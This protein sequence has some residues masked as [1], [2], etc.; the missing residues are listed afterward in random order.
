MKHKALSEIRHGQRVYARLPAVYF[1]VR[2]LGLESQAAQ[3]ALDDL[4][5]HGYAWKD[6]ESIVTYRKTDDG[7]K[8][9]D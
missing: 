9:T 7:K 4:V 2:A 8:T 1:E 3:K 5:K 6:G